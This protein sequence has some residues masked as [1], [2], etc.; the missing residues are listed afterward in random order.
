[1]MTTEIDGQL[2]LMNAQISALM[3]QAAELREARKNDPEFSE[4]AHLSVAEVAVQLA[5]IEIIGL[6]TDEPDPDNLRELVSKYARAL[7]D[8]I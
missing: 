2:N 8:G 3:K 1:M 4:W 5:E 7:R 6:E